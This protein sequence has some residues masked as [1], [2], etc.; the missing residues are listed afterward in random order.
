MLEKYNMIFDVI[1]Y[2]NALKQSIF[3]SR[4][5]YK[6][7][8]N[9]SLAFLL[10]INFFIFFFFFKDIDRQGFGFTDAYFD[11]NHI[12]LKIFG[13]AHFIVSCLRLVLW[14]SY[15][16]RI[17]AMKEWRKLFQK[18][19]KKLKLNPQ[20]V[21]TIA[22]VYDLELLQKNYTDLD[23]GQ[24]MKLLQIHSSINDLDMTF[25]IL[26]NLI[27][28]IKFIVKSGYFRFICF[29]VIISYMAHFRNINFFYSILLVDI[30]NFDSTLQ[31]VTK[32]ITLNYD[33][34][35][36][37]GILLLVMVYLFSVI[38]FYVIGQ[39]FFMKR[40]SQSQI[41]ENVCNTV[42]QCFLTNLNFVTLSLEKINL[43]FRVQEAV[44]LSEM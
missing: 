22:S 39:D 19:A 43:I 21:G 11:E 15:L 12:L 17:E 34:L 2:E 26:D 40:I 8:N 36:L 31:N 37:T 42:F 38:G 33:T 27:Y 1:V 9:S 3:M 10:V 6:L 25:P 18:V 44:E 7:V 13:L 35:I 24:R 32:S 41:G 16:G 5:L 20:W 14:A 23:S 4:G 28:Q 29:Y 30:T